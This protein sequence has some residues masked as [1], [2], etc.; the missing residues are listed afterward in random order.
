MAKMRKS[1]KNR[2]KRNTLFSSDK[3][4]AFLTTVGKRKTILSDSRGWAL[5]RKVGL[6]DVPL[7]LVIV[8]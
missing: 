7:Y 8:Q 5:N 3:K 4:G 1:G 2:K 6:I